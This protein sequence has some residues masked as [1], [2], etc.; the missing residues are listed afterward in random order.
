MVRVARGL[1]GWSKA[2]VAPAAPATA[3]VM[4]PDRPSE[5]E[6]PVPV[7]LV[8]MLMA[9][10]FWPVPGWGGENKTR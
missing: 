4:P 10:D 1:E 6:L 3:P 7:T 8:G 2:V 9:S 5:D